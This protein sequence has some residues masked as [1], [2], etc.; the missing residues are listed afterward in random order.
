MFY[1]RVFTLDHNTR[2]QF[3]REIG[4]FIL[5]FSRLSMHV[6]SLLHLTFV[7][8]YGNPPMLVMGRCMTV[9]PETENKFQPNL[10]VLFELSICNQLIAGRPLI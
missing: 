4:C 2:S 5:E 3:R 10:S 8:F 6:I 1:Y 7:L 9:R